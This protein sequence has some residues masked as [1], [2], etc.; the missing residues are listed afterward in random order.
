MVVGVVWGAVQARALAS[1]ARAASEQV[2]SVRSAIGA[3]DLAGAAA[4]TQAAAREAAAARRAADS[5]PF[6]VGSH[7]P[8]KPGEVVGAV[9]TTVAAVDRA[10]GSGAVPA[11]SSA[12]QAL[13]GGS[14]IRSDGSL[15]PA[16]MAE[17][18][19]ALA[20]AAAATRSARDQ[21][22]TID[23][24][25]LPPGLSE[26]VARAQTGVDQLADGLSRGQALMS[27]L[28]GILGGDGRKTYLVAFQNT[29]E[30]RPTGGIIGTWAL[31]DASDG[32]LSLAETGSNDDLE[33]LTGPVRD[34]GPEYSAL[35]PSEQASY[36]QNVGLSPHFP[37]A[38]QLL[39]DLWTAQ[40]RRAPDGVIAV[41]PS[42]LAP[43]LEGAGTVEV[44]GGPSVSA[45]D[46]VDVVLRQSYEVFRDDNAA[47]KD[48][49][50]ALVGAAFSRGLGGGAW[51]ARRLV[52]LGS[53]VDAHHL[54]IWSADPQ[55]E[56]A[57]V[58]G[59]AA[60]VLPEPED[61][62][63]G[64]YL[65]N[66]SASKLDYY[67][68]ESVRTQGGCSAPPRI[69]LELTNDAPPE[70]PFYVSTKVEGYPPTTEL[71]TVAVYLPPD[72]QVTDVLVDGER[73]EVEVLTE[74]GWN[75]NRLAVA[76]PRASTVTVELST[77]GPT[78][79]ITT[80]HTQPLAT[81]PAVVSPGCR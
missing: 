79:P 71:L 1:H 68:R 76:V 80:V 62:A 63:A 58:E 30:V 52:A 41:D 55:E 5:A 18:A 74:R 77:S 34:L 60:G 35:Y 47:R 56:A 29:A 10:V 81:A 15:D 42:G 78:T 14:V 36:S 49:L 6:V 31:L 25:G 66:I 73:A 19:Q 20:P 61:H 22:R 48:Y 21:L 27:V 12:S 65:T 2:E 64:V 38:A 24:A 8:G 43:L 16:G 26:S 69:T 3:G 9:R 17:L 11:V 28:P 57:L 44:P 72:R 54:Q 45:D 67:M 75:V 33:R 53:A 7:V 50:T 40:G 13:A 39:T 70:V 23:V 37:H 46:V 32:R 59:G 4:A 51:D